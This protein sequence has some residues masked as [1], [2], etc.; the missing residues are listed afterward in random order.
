MPYKPP[1]DYRSVAPTWPSAREKAEDR[2]LQE[3]TEASSAV[4]KNVT[5]DYR[6]ALDLLE[7]MKER[8][9]PRGIDVWFHGYRACCA[10][11]AW[12]EAEKVI[13]AMASEDRLS[14]E[15][16]FFHAALD[17][18]YRGQA[19]SPPNEFAEN[20]LQDMQMRGMSPTAVT[21]QKAV[22]AVMRAGN[23]SIAD[24]FFE[25]A[26]K[27]GLLT[28][29]INKGVALRLFDMPKAM[30][31]IVLRYA[32]EQRAISLT[33]RKAGKRGIT[34]LTEDPGGKKQA[35]LEADVLRVLREQY[36]LKAKNTA[37]FGRIDIRGEDLERLGHELLAA[38]RTP[39]D[40]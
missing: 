13:L 6:V 29:W 40:T 19:S 31:R 4:C 25:T 32:V 28:I 23:R 7:K 15:H 34:I 21:Y 17:G 8:R 18:M 26:E 11:G 38:K 10:A 9:L 12:E 33:G 16:R 5:A 36:K 14:P 20:L 35:S 2:F 39:N 1:P 27:R 30:A 22:E 3:L 37:G 24:A